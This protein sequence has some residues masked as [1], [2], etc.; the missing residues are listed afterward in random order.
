VTSADDGPGELELRVTQLHYWLGDAFLD[1]V[2]AGEM[3][4]LTPG[5]EEVV[6][7]I[8]E[9]CSRAAARGPAVPAVFLVSDLMGFDVVRGTSVLNSLRVRAGGDI[10]SV[11][12][13]TGDAVI[14]GLRAL[15][16][17]VYGQLLLPDD[18]GGLA[19]RVS[20]QS[21]AWRLVM[22]AIK[23]DPELPF[24][25][26]S[27]VG[28]PVRMLT[29][30]GWGSGHQLT[31]L[32]PSLV[33]LAWQV[34]RLRIAQPSV[35]LLLQAIPD[36]VASARAAFAGKRVTATG[37]ASF[38]GVLLPEGTELAFDW[39]TLRPAREADHPRGV[40]RALGDRRLTRH[41]EDG[42][43]VVIS[44]VG[45]IIL[46][47]TVP[48]RLQLG[49][50]FDQA[51]GF[52]DLSSQQDLQRRITQ[53]RLALLLASPDPQPPPLLP[54]WRRF[55]EPSAAS[56]GWGWSDPQHFAGRMPTQLTPEQADE[57]KTWIEH[58][59]A[60]QPGRLGV[61]PQRLLRATA[62]RRDA[63]DSLIDAVIVWES[64]FSAADEASLRVSVAMAKLL[65]PPGDARRQ[66]R[67]RVAE[68]YRLRS[69]VVHGSETD[70]QEVAHASQEAATLATGVL[71][72]LITDHPDLVLKD[73]GARSLAILTDRL[74][75]SGPPA[76]D[77]W[78]RPLGKKKC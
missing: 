37:L 41:L 31:F 6:A 62:E 46:T 67:K 49:K 12:A 74:P 52:P 71:R 13:A 55:V 30:T 33:S 8:Y 20:P 11:P 36:A 57:W 63:S 58:L 1:W 54:V 18:T 77:N 39:G 7:R 45:D 5:Q 35:E 43:D 2:L 48:Y 21:P 61:A 16:I 26:S 70:L 29:S 3:P 73:S 17:E 72:I 76:V 60:I 25:D 28:D 32:G 38:T 14:D 24:D 15:A 65:K 56:A 66:L 51:K 69:K 19:P 27:D 23:Q 42:T 68:I 78:P 4:P 34:A 10:P 50:E 22:E 44:D 40:R 9:V 53:V 47:A 64:L 59:D 75:A